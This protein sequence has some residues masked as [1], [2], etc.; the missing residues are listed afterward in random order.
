MV[1]E[2]GGKVTRM[3][4]GQFCVFDRSVLVSNG[5]MHT[6]VSVLIVFLLT[7]LITSKF[8]FL[9][10]SLFMLLVQYRYVKL[11]GC[12]LHI[13]GHNFLSDIAKLK[14]CIA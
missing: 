2:A 9:N 13:P 10:T 14:E 6:K 11:L 4:G 3:D 5:V 7:C 12:K 1:E 8:T